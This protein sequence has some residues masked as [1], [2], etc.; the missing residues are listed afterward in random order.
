MLSTYPPKNCGLA[1]FTAAL[2]THLRGHPG[3][4]PSCEIEVIA[5]SDPSD[6]LVYTDP[7]V[8]YELRVDSVSVTVK[9]CMVLETLLCSGKS[10]I[11][12]ALWCLWPDLLDFN[13]SAVDLAKRRYRRAARNR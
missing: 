2:L 7:I 13:T 6:R 10:S 3:L 5:L 12:K 11:F 1:T 8:K 9:S 4:P